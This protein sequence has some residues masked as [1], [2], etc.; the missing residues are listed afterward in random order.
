MKISEILTKYAWKS[1]GE[2]GTD[3]NRCKKWGH[4]YGLAYDN[5][6]KSF[7]RNSKLDII[8][9]GIEF[10]GSLIAWKEFFPNANV[11]GIDIEDKVPKKRDNI[12]YIISDFKD[13]KIKKEYDI[14]IDD[15]S[16]RLSDVVKAVKKFKLKVGGV[17][18]IEDCK[19]PAHWFEKIKKNTK[20]TIELIDLREMYGQSDDYL[21]ILRNYGYEE[22]L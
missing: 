8:E 13:L 22:I 14:V 2:H 10:G 21:I 3:K 4:C 1:D 16:H 15:G 7:D 18:I 12:E 9:I 11:T 5:I 19:A 20:Y 17:M 6:F